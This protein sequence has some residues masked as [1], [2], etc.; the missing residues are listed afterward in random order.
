MEIVELTLKT[1]HLRRQRDFY[2]DRLGFVLLDETDGR[3]T[4]DAGVSR[5][6]FEQDDRPT[7]PY[8]F[9]FNIPLNQM[10][11]AELWLAQQVEVL[12]G[13]D[14]RRLV[15]LADPWQA[16]SLY[17]YD[18]AGN[19]VELI[20]RERLAC[21]TAVPF[22]AQSIWNISEI[23]LVVPDVP[24]LVAALEDVAAPFGPGSHDFQPVGDDTGMMIVVQTG[25]VWFPTGSV[26]AAA[27]PLTLTLRG[28][29]AGVRHI[30]HS[31]YTIRTV[32]D[33]FVPGGPA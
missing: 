6:H 28:P 33:A 27:A 16:Q 13:S 15:Q 3:I 2:V 10:A 4:L 23:G 14:G 18:P 1:Q 8:H 20:A 29:A 24:R 11:D 5:L 31:P 7:A 22:S 9:A 12:P 26:R 17:F 19:V 21:G 25:R 32:T 30:P